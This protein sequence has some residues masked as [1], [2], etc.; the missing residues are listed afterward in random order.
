M[1]EFP[2]LYNIYFFQPRRTKF[3]E[4]RMCHASVVKPKP[5]SQFFGGI[6]FCCFWLIWEIQQLLEFVCIIDIQFICEWTICIDQ[7][8]EILHTI[9]HILNSI[10]CDWKIVKISANYWLSNQLS[11]LKIIW[12]IQN[13]NLVIDCRNMHPIYPSNF[14][15][16]NVSMTNFWVL[17]KIF[18]PSSWIMAIA[19][20]WFQVVLCNLILRSRN[21][22]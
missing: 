16:Q 18:E 2:I 5:G 1:Y 11:N 10:N 4:L 20:R 3:G 15:L 12:S 6:K 9:W 14:S 21:R 8:L 17:R 7:I 13:I 22:L 19:T